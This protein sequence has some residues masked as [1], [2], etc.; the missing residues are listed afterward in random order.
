MLIARVTERSRSISE[1]M[2]KMSNGNQIQD[3]KKGDMLP[4][5]EASE[6]TG[7]KL[8]TFR[9]WRRMCKVEPTKYPS[10]IKVGGRLYVIKSMLIEHIN[11]ELTREAS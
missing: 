11:R 9:H 1:V 7:I 5:E 8:C 10:V 2:N 6:Q 4:I 3:L